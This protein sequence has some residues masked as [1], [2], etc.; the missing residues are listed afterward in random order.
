MANLSLITEDEV[1]VVNLTAYP[2]QLISWT[3]SGACCYLFGQNTE[4]CG[5][6]ISL[7]SAQSVE[8]TFTGLAGVIDQ[9]SR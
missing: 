4:N 6:N 1:S 5:H 2:W 9:V 3:P 8:E 7:A